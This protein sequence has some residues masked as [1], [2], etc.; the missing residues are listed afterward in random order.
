MPEQNNAMSE[1]DSQELQLEISNLKGTITAL[2]DALEKKQVETEQQ[3]QAV[4]QVSTDQIKQLEETIDQMRIRLEEEYY[5]RDTHIQEITQSLND[6]LK[7]SQ[8]TVIDLRDQ[9]ENKK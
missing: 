7:Q 1:I 6:Q 8:E 4:R 9:L 3:L 5:S 2:R